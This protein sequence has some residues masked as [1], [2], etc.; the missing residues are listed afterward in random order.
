MAKRRKRQRSGIP[1]PWEQRTAALRGVVAGSRFR[2][3]LLALTVGVSAWGIYHAASAELRMRQT[4]S[5]IDEV[6]RA[7]A[8]FRA[9]VGRCPETAAELTDPPREGRRYLRDLPVDGWGH[10]LYVSCP[11]YDDP[12]GAEVVSAGPSGDFFLDDNVR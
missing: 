5:A 9:E 3:G 8:A 4:R 11:A 10:E 6:H 7:I 12:D 2:V 1:L